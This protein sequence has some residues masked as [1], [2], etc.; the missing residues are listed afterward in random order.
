[1][2]SYRQALYK[3]VPACD[4]ET[5]VIGSGLRGEFRYTLTSPT[6]I[7]THEFDDQSY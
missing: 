4:P 3:C 6:Q 7:S 1:M 2:Q 5:L